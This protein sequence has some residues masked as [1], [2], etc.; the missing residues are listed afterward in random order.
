VHPQSRGV[1]LELD[2][3]AMK[4]TLRR[5]YTHP[6]KLVSTSQG[7]MQVLPNGNVFVGWGSQPFVSEFSHDGELLFDA[8][9]PPDDDSYR[10]FRFPW[11]GQ[12]D[13]APD[14]AADRRSDDEVTLY[15][16]WNG[17]TEI[18]S[19]EVLS[20]PH[21]DQLEPLGSVPRDGFETA[22]SARTEEPYVAVRA[23]NSSGRVLGTSSPVKRESRSG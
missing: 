3:E 9:I 7:N 19:W 22:I 18:E 5:A 17:A 14:V 4:A 8:S 2:E 6:D 12:P 1:V 11:K 23:R 15:A 13:R 20:G 16:S 21:Q 10:A